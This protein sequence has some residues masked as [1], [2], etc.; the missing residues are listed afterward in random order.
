MEEVSSCRCLSSL[1]SETLR[2]CVVFVGNNEVIFI[3]DEISW[4]YP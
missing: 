2:N 1:P 3:S 4:A